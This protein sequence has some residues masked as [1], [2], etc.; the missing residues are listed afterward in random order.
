MPPTKARAAMGSAKNECLAHK[1]VDQSAFFNS[2]LGMFQRQLS[3]NNRFKMRLEKDVK[4]GIARSRL[5]DHSKR[6]PG[7]FRHSQFV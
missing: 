4:C 2:L 7:R 5:E 3:T 6:G 1:R